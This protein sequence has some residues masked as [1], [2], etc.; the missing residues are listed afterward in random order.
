M[1][2]YTPRSPSLLDLMARQ[3]LAFQKPF[4]GENHLGKEY[5]LIPSMR[6]ESRTAEGSVANPVGLVHE[7]MVGHMGRGKSSKVLHGGS[8]G[9]L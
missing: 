8:V 6:R 7:G 5:T 9:L 2:L 4:C 1:T 3:H